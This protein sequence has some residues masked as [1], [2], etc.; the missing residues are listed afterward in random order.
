MLLL[1]R[2]FVG[3]IRPLKGLRRPKRLLKGL[4]LLV[5]SASEFEDMVG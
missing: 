4:E 2:L 5:M 1:I 3:L